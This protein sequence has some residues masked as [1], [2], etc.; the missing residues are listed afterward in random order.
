MV[1]GDIACQKI[2][3][4][5]HVIAFRD[6]SPQAP[7]HVLVIPKI[8]VESIHAL[9]DKVLAGEILSAA[10][11][12]AEAEGIHEGYRLVMNTGVEA[13]QSVFHLHIHVLGGRQMNWPPG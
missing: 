4:N 6:I 7:S 12:V 10:T 2:F 5:D 1:A 9:E 3:E 11:K 8:H 13:G